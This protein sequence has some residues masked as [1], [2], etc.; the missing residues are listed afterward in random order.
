MDENDEISENEVMIVKTSSKHS[1]KT[2]GFAWLLGASGLWLEL[3][4]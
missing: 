2:S 3:I 4:C 1:I